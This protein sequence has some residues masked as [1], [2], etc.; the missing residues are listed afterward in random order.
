[1]D[2][3]CRVA[4]RAELDSVRWA[5]VI[6]SLSAGVLLAVLDLFVW[7]GGPLSLLAWL[8]AAVLGGAAA[9]ALDEPRHPPTE[10]VPTS[11]RLRTGC[12]LVLPLLACAG[13]AAYAWQAAAA[14]RREGG[15]VSWSPLVLVGASAVVAAAGAAALLRRAGHDEP[16]GVVASATVALSVGLALV[17]LP[18]RLYPYDVSAWNRT[19]ALW[20]A[21]AVLGLAALWRGTRDAWSTAAT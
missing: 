11:R 20:S 1:M 8:T 19:S 10:A 3:I 2:V 21:F 15:T 12:R 16:G 9:L 13:W 18:G 17:P 7:P 6:V 14:V 5:P 4:L